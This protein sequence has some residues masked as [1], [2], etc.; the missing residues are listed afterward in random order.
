MNN[1][2]SNIEIFFSKLFSPVI[3]KNTIVDTIIYIIGLRLKDFKRKADIM[4]NE[5]I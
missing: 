5:D 2:L 1:Q 3:L 4:V